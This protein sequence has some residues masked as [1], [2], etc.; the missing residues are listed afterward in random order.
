MAKLSE[1]KQLQ[2]FEYMT[3]RGESI[4]DLSPETKE[5]IDE[6]M[7]GSYML[8]KLNKM[9]N[10]SQD[11]RDELINNLGLSHLKYKS[12][13]EAR[14]TRNLAL[15]SGEILDGVT[16]IPVISSIA[17]A[18]NKYKHKLTTLPKDRLNNRHTSTRELYDEKVKLDNF[19]KAYTRG[20]L[21]VAGTLGKT[22]PY[23]VSTLLFPEATLPALIRDATVNTAIGVAEYQG[24]KDY[25]HNAGSELL[26]NTVANIGAL[27]ILGLL[28]NFVKEP[29][30]MSELYN[31]EITNILKTAKDKGID[32]YSQ[33]FK[34]LSTRANNSEAFNSLISSLSKTKTKAIDELNSGSSYTFIN[35]TKKDLF[36]YINA[37]RETK[38]KLQQFTDSK[39]SI[40]NMLKADL[41]DRHISDTLND[42]NKFSD[43]E[44]NNISNFISTS[45][46]VDL[47]NKATSSI[48]NP[49]RL[50]AYEDLV[51]DTLVKLDKS[52]VRD[53]T[54]TEFIDFITTLDKS[55]FNNEVDN[56]ISLAKQS[57]FSSL[58]STVTSFL[59][60]KL[61]RYSYNKDVADFIKNPDTSKLTVSQYENI[62]KHSSEDTLQ[63]LRLHK[64]KEMLGKDKG[65]FYRNLVKQDKSLIK[66][67]FPED[68]VLSYKDLY[69]LAEI[70]KLVNNR[71]TALTNLSDNTSIQHT[72]NNVL[73]TLGKY[74][75]PIKIFEGV[76]SIFTPNQLQVLTSKES[77]LP[78]I[79][80][81]YLLTK[82][83]ILAGKALSDTQY[84][85]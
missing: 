68:N 6:T 75:L 59:N 57:D 60:N 39:G 53:L 80:K 3:A 72:L 46:V 67:M 16:S 7:Y 38:L 2:V 47:A 28:N 52:E 4:K 36:K 77:K 79:F 58:N 48:S 62:A 41:A 78:D 69:T 15:T 34:N 49:V 70:G 85:E 26:F 83:N 42:L 13:P 27:G 32:I 14:F 35:K 22:T 12:S 25:N 11:N 81:A 44:V 71:A 56:I 66:S 18:F 19:Y 31:P 30:N 43:Y 74:S 65:M 82:E 37:L 63:L 40:D 10:V 33:D 21:D 17:K 50:K 9:P 51:Q 29:L 76:K 8:D 64:L 73:N 61:I 23:L 54:S 24:S 45:K 1:D 55:G 20:D 84:E 5:L